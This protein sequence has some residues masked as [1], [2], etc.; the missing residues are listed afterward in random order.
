M[1]A[2][3][4]ANLKIAS[5]V[6]LVPVWPKSETPAALRPVPNCILGNGCGGVVPVPAL[7]MDA[8]FA[9][10]FAG[11][12]HSPLSLMAQSRHGDLIS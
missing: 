12:D 11:Q 4:P 5:I 3:Q 1:Y 7:E 6:Q 8:A 10:W 9:N 2:A